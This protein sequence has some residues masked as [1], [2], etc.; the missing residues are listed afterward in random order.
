MSQADLAF[1]RDVSVLVL[2]IQSFVILVVVIGISYFGFRLL[3]QGHRWLRL[4]FPLWQ[5]IALTVRD[6]TERYAAKAAMPVISVAATASAAATVARWFT[7]PLRR[8]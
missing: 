1:W 3:R 6:T 4:Q 2:A 8:R 5:G 7:S